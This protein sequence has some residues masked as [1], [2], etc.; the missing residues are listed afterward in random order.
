MNARADRPDSVPCE[1]VASRAA[2]S[3]V[4]RLAMKLAT[5]RARVPAFVVASEALVDH[6]YDG[7]VIKGGAR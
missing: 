7:F 1:Y 2:D 5:L 4:D 3:H 6:E